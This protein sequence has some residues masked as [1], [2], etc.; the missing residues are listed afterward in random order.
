MALYVSTALINVAVAM[1]C[2][3]LSYA[4]GR[5]WIYVVSTLAAALVTILGI[6]V[7]KRQP[8][9][10][11]KLSGT[12]A[13][14]CVFVLLSWLAELIHA[15]P[16]REQPEQEGMLIGPFALLVL[17]ILHLAITILNS[18]RSENINP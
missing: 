6:L 12:G 15:I 16:F 8:T 4:M 2:L 1:T 13:A 18:R 11:A 5:G 10:A 3:F 14:I 7:C 17:S 9:L